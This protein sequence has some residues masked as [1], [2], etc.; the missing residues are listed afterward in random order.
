MTMVAKL[1]L[2]KILDIIF[3]AIMTFIAL[4]QPSFTLFAWIYFPS[5]V[6]YE[7]IMIWI[8]IKQYGKKKVIE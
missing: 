7:T 2:I 5:L 6:V 8:L 3:L 4:I 1:S